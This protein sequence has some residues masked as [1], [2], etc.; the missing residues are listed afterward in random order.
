MLDRASMLRRVAIFF[1]TAGVVFGAL[2]IG[3]GKQGVTLELG[4]ISTVEFVADR[5]ITVV[6]E[7]ATEV[8]E[9]VAREAV[10]PVL[11]TDGSV[12]GEVRS[13]ISEVLD[14]VE[15]SVVDTPPAISV[16]PLPDEPDP[17]TTTSPSTTVP[18]E[19]T[20]STTTTTVPV[21][22][23]TGTVTGQ[24]FI[25]V[26]E[27][28]DLLFDEGIDV[29]L[30][31]IDVTVVG[32]DGFWTT[33]SSGADGSFTA[34]DVVVD[35][36]VI[37][38]I[39]LEDPSL[40]ES[41]VISSANQRQDLD[42]GGTDVVAEAFVFRPNVVPRDAAESNLLG[43]YPDLDLAT[44]ATLV[45]VAR[46]DIVR[47]ARGRSPQLSQIEA[48]ALDAAGNALE[49]GIEESE[50]PAVRAQIKQSATTRLVIIDGQPDESASAAAADLAGVFLM[51]NRVED[52]ALFLDQQDAAAELVP[53]V[54]VDYS[55][56]ELI[57]GV[58]EEISQPALA[59]I[60]G[61]DLN[62]PD[63]V[64]YG[65]LAVLSAVLVLMI[66]AYLARFRPGF[67]PPTAVFPSSASSSCSLP[68]PSAAWNW[69]RARSVTTPTSLGTPS[70][71]PASGS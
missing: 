56:G 5:S 36:P 18:D 42:G 59:A 1:M 19:E 66:F 9:Q 12:E 38:A 33:V 58:G 51:A 24:V 41:L 64:G 52:E 55:P 7:A 50:V 26:G 8:A 47:I 15:A 54:E 60:E 13:R 25:D 4:A 46:E 34:E 70:R 63:P 31:G 67:W 39:D 22:L 43:A 65:A 28:A 20:P 49:S 35:G 6:D 48:R 37:V 53:D 21:E 3:Q 16:T 61:L 69:P 29:A 45:D 2:A 68:S 44:V 27:E 17:T 10:E 11:R 62:R 40:P 57:V 23:V 71:P 30:V 14:E 32:A